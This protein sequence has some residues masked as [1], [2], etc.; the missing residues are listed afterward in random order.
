MK[1]FPRL[2]V[3]VGD[4]AAIEEPLRRPGVGEVVP[5]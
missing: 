5:P 3:V 4:R 2:I 1:P